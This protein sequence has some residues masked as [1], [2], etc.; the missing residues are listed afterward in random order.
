MVRIKTWKYT[1]TKTPSNLNRF[2]RLY[3]V[4]RPQPK[5]WGRSPQPHCPPPST[6]GY[7]VPAGVRSTLRALS[8]GNLVVPRTRWRIGGFFCCCTASM[9]QAT[10]GAETAAIDGLVSSWSENILVSF[11]LR[12]SSSGR[13]TSASV[14]VTVTVCLSVAISRRTWFFF[15]NLE[16]E[17]CQ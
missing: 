17:I 6:G 4:N 10:D 8:C 15:T 2:E 16:Q 9:E 3:C 12:S 13:N 7:A 5:M 14:T 11:C 1:S